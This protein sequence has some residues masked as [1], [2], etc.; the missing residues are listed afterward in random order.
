MAHETTAVAGVENLT[1]TLGKGITGVDDARDVLENNVASAFPILD[2]EELDIDVARAFGRAVSVNHLDRGLV[3]LVE[4]SGG[5]LGKT[6]LVKN[7][8]KVFGYFGSS[9]GGDELCLS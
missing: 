7:E 2:R 9:N 8:T 1:N 6:K 4:R 5:K 3:V